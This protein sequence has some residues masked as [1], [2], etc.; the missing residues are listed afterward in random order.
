MMKELNSVLAVRNVEKQR[1]KELRE[2]KKQG[3]S[4]SPNDASVNSSQ[5]PDEQKMPKILEIT[6]AMNSSEEAGILKPTAME[7]QLAR[8]DGIECPIL[9]QES[10]LHVS[11]EET[12]ESIDHEPHKYELPFHLSSSEQQ[13]ENSTLTSSAIAQAVAAIALRAG[14]ANKEELFHNDEDSSCTSSEDEIDQT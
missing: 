9:P 13:L 2:R 5:P 11:P 12:K 3:G 1:K 8:E 10:E 7:N 6:V 14:R 4:H